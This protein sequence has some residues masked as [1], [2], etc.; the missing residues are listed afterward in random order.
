[1]TNAQPLTD[2]PKRNTSAET[3][4]LEA[5]AVEANGTPAVANE[6]NANEF[7]I[8]AGHEGYQFAQGQWYRDGEA[9]ECDATVALRDV[10]Q[11]A[12]AGDP[13]AMISLGR[14]YSFVSASVRSGMSRAIDW[15][16]RAAQ[17]GMALGYV[18]AG[19]LF[20]A[21]GNNEWAARSFRE[22]SAQGIAYADECLA[23]L[24]VAHPMLRLKLE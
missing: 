12:D 4:V 11:A 19:K 2:N 24:L 6:V 9:V 20:A 17:K 18:L 13:V 8:V 5:N 23:Q 22:A 10:K 15:F 16:L 14:W 7:G 3:T 21:S 1:M